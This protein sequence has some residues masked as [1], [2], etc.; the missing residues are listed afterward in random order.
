MANRKSFDEICTHPPVVEVSSVASAM[1]IYPASV[2]QCE[3]TSQADRLLSGEIEGFAY[4]RDGHPNAVA[5]AEQCRLLQGGD[6]LDVAFSHITS[7]GMSAL[8]LAMVTHL[9]S[10]DHVL[11]S[12]QLY[13][14]T[15]RLVD[16]ELARWGLEFSEVNMCDLDQVKAA[17]RSNTRM[18]VI[19]TIANPL[20]HVADIGSLSEIAHRGNAKLL[21]DNTF[22]TP[23][24]VRP[25]EFGADLVM[26]SM[27]KIMNG[28]GDVM[29]GLLCGKA[30]LA[31]RARD[32]LSSWGM[33]SSPF[34]CWL[35][36]RGLATADLRIARA[37]E[38]ASC[39]AKSLAEHPRI[40]NVYFPGLPTHPTHEM[41]QQ[42]LGGQ[43]F[44]GMLSIEF[45]GGAKDV[46][47]FIKVSQKIAF[48]PSLGEIATTISHPRST[49]H[50]GLSEESAKR[51]GISPG[52]MRISCGIE[53]HEFLEDE[54]K[55]I[56]EAM[57]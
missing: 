24:V 11:L 32:A 38:N 6:N 14:R 53:S 25:F 20:L 22:A 27:T 19:E 47:L 56:L 4:Q 26:E 21:V 3:S 49:S 13:G 50:R 10:G 51:L 16:E 7:T 1:P 42:V 33:T 52:L 45:P 48:C 12:D 46:D 30:D 54:F 40:K 17:I 5:L 43:R 8:S 9:K 18:V 39:L 36:S 2:Y 41:A 37:N 57:D 23:L 44:G 28:H 55:T 34:D 29:M 15:T 31:K 35:A